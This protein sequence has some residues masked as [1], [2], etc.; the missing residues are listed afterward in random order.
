MGTNVC[1]KQKKHVKA[2]CENMQLRCAYK[3]PFDYQSIKNENGKE[4]K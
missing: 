1:P 2:S 4:R 3:K